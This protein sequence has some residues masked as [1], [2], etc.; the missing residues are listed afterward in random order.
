MRRLAARAGALLV[1]VHLAGIAGANAQTA[2]V[3]LAPRATLDRIGELI[4]RSDDE[5]SKA[6]ATALATWPQD[7]A[8]H[9]FAGVNDTHRGATASA[10]SHF[11]TAIRLAPQVPGA[12]I[13]LGRLYQERSAVDATA[14]SKAIDVYRR[15]LT[16]EPTNSEALFQAGLLLTLEGNFAESLTF[17]NRLPEAVR[18]S[19]QVLATMAVARE[20]SGDSAGALSATEALAAHPKLVA[21]D[22]LAV[23][24]A[25]ARLRDDRIPQALLAA[26]DA[27]GLGASAPV[28]IELGRLAARRGDAKVA[29]GYLAHARSLEPQNPRIHFLFGIV[30]V[31]ADLGREAYDSLKKAVELDPENPQVNYA[32]GAVALHRHDPS[33]SIPYFERYVQLAPNDIRG[34]FALGAARYYSNQLDAARRDLEAAAASPQTAA[35]ARYYLARIARQSDD[36]VTARREIDQAVALAP[37]HA[38]AWAELGLIETRAGRY[39]EAGRALSKALAIDPENYDATR[40]LAALYGRTRDPRRA[41]QEARLAA[42]I[43]KREARM[44]DFLRLVEVVP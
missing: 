33:E 16:V 19:P 2:K 5:A 29:L 25:F 4:A 14:R 9:Y 44:Q 23:Q 18:A 13:T 20:G 27:R 34:R 43:E 24:P 36:L 30:C 6:I 37:G 8:L 38:D 40:H 22:V 11:L 15:L 26:L 28:L 42:L 31:Q 7:P 12:Y 41:D 1:C 17:L 10:E 3:T 21:A 35:G 32:M 39:E